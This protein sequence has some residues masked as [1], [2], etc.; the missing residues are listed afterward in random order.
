LNPYLTLCT[1]WI[2]DLNIRPETIELL[3]EHTGE[4]PDD[5]RLGNGLLGTTPK[6]QTTKAKTDKWSTKLENFC[7]P[8]DTIQSEKATYGMGEYS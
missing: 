4:T 1:K 6:A 8:K 7:T 2:K 3:G 5:T